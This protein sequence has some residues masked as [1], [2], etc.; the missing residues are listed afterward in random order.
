MLKYPFRTLMMAVSLAVLAACS[1]AP[2]TPVATPA[3]PLDPAAY[4]K[5]VDIICCITGHL[6]VDDK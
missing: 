4:T 2:Y 3:E 1:S 6:R 5:K